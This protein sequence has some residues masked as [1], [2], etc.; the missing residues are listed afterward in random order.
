MSK[1]RRRQKRS[2][3]R[4]KRSI[5]QVESIPGGFAAQ[6]LGTVRS[7]GSSYGHPQ[8]NHQLTAD[9]LSAWLSRRLDIPIKLSAEDVCVMNILQKIS[10]IAF[11]TKDDSLL[12]IAG[13]TENVAMLA[14]SQRNR[15]ATPEPGDGT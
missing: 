1:E 3:R 6:V 13:Y 9:L 4:Q 11:E 14:P 12:D 10:R 2:K 5:R 8:D 15:R 7:R